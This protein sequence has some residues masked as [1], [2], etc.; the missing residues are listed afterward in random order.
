MICCQVSSDMIGRLNL[1]IQKSHWHLFFFFKQNI[2][3]GCH[4]DPL[5]R[6]FIK[7]D[8]L[9]QIEIIYKVFLFFITC[10]YSIYWLIS[11]DYTTSYLSVSFDFPS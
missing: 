1:R 3:N 9:E 11:Y 7:S 2:E 8:Q 6:A 5:L 4:L 10:L